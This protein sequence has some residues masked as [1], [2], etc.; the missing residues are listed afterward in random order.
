M[1]TALFRICLVLCTVALWPCPLHA[2]AL[3]IP[4]LDAQPD[5]QKPW[6]DVFDRVRNS[7]VLI[8]IQLPGSSQRVKGSGFVVTATGY[9]LTNDHVVVPPGERRAVFQDGSAYPFSIVVTDH[10]RDLALI[11]IHAD[12]PFV[13]LAL[14]RSA[15][16]RT[17]DP[18]MVVGNP[19]GGGMKATDGIVSAIG[20]NSH[21]GGPLSG[22][23]IE[24]D[25]RV[26]SGNSGG[27]VI[28]EAAEAIGIISSVL[29]GADRISF[30][31]P[32]DLACTF[33]PDLLWDAG[34]LHFQTGMTIAPDGKG[35]VDEVAADSPAAA[36]GIRRSDRITQIDGLPVE[37]GIDVSIALIDRSA[38]DTVAVHLRRVGGEQIETQL[39][40]AEVE[41]IPAE[42]PARTAPGLAFE[43]YQGAWDTLPPFDD[44][45]PVET[46]VVDAVDIE[47]Y[48]GSDH[49]ALRFTG[50]IRVPRDGMYTFHLGSDDGSRLTVAGKLVVNNNGLHPVVVK[51]GF[52]DLAAGLHPITLTYFESA[53]DEGLELT[54]S[55]PGI[56][57]QAVP[58]DALF[59]TPQEEILVQ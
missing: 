59:H 7:V 38:G 32:T 52:I 44:L 14:G 3:S 37:R 31:I 36:A 49:F 42:Q 43:F 51:N 12:K 47:P 11:K 46:G 13:P 28:N 20:I 58:K 16:V 10:D 23:M 17:G 56:A 57:Q 19:N 5:A 48:K 55:G 30:A 40:L 41:V 54:Y 4:P 27:P 24:T 1:T 6:A 2:D 50:Y 53:G 45:T 34:Y 15:R 18:V 21:W 26:V 22:K 8:D 9:A 33:L 39:T 25:A 29:T 35:R